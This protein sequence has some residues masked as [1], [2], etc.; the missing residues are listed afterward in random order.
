MTRTHHIPSRLKPLFTGF[1]ALLLFGL[2]ACK[3]DTPNNPHDPNTLPP[4]T[5]EGKNTFGCKVNGEVW[6][7]YMPSTVG[8]SVA[9]EGTFYQDVGALHL[10]ANRKLDNPNVSDRVDVVLLELHIEGEYEMPTYN[11]QMRGF[12]DYLNNH[13]CSKYYFHDDLL[14]KVRITYFS[15]NKRIISGTFEMDL[16]NPSCPGDT[17]RIRE[18]RFDWRY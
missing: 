14:R 11:N 15:N 12:T 1:V 13:N 8:G 16:I 5:H 10:T 7:A 3:K 17:I 4:L 18:G 9:L 2:V 6:V